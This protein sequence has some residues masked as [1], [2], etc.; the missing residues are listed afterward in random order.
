MGLWESRV[1]I[2]LAWAIKED[3]QREA[4]GSYGG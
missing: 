4:S 1:E 2:Y 3:F